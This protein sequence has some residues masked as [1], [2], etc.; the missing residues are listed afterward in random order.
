MFRKMRRKDKAMTQDQI[1]EI[2]NG[3]EDGV[4]ATVGED[5][6]P[7]AVPLNYVFHEGALYFHCA[8]FGHKI[9]NMTYTPKVSFCVVSDAQV[10]AEE[11]STRFKSVVVFGEVEEVSGDEK[12]QGLTALIK[13][14]ASDHI[15]AGQKYIKKDNKKTRVFKINVAHMSGKTAH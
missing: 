7:Y 8:L 14:L 12:I 15:P 10:L 9:E 4:L 6:Y 13:R 11:F 1:V 2:L 3:G 5:G